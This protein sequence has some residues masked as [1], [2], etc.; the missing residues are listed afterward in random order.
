MSYADL[1]LYLLD[2]AMVATS[3]AKIPQPQFPRG[4]NSN[5]KCSYH[6]G[7]RGHSIE[8]CMTLKYKVQSLIDAGWLRFEEE[9]HLWILMSSSNT[10]HDAWGNLK[11][12]VRCFQWL[13]RIF[14]CRNLP[15]GG[16]ATR[17]SRVRLPWEKNARSRHQCLFEENV[18]KTGKVW[19]MNFKC[20]RFGSCFYAR[21]RY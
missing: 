1:L 3:P 6:R 19:S 4:Y 9:N 2:N 18:R 14:R 21:G 20:E 17:G 10:M 16:R 15:F 7:V 12:V 11:V 5:V 8:H 13:I